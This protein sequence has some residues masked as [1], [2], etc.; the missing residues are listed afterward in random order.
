MPSCSTQK[1]ASVRMDGH[2]FFN[3]FKI[4]LDIILIGVSARA[5]KKNKNQLNISFSN[6]G[7]GGGV[8]K[9]SLSKEVIEES[10][11][12]DSGTE[13]VVDEMNKLDIQLENESNEN[14]S[15]EKEQ[16]KS[17]RNGL[18]KKQFGKKFELAIFLLIFI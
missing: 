10:E 13:E 17:D 4:I 2:F 18:G 12:N 1:V 14:E 16:S 5:L 9:N 3:I 7:G 11:E 6:N 8:D 15:S